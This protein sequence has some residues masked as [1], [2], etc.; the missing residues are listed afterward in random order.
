MILLFDTPGRHD[1]RDCL[2]DVM[3][4]HPAG[5]SLRARPGADVCADASTP[6]AAADPAWRQH[7]VWLRAAVRHRF[8]DQIADD[9]AQETYLRVVTR[10]SADAI[11]NPRGL[12]MAVA[13]NLARDVFRRERLRADYAARNARPPSDATQGL[14]TA[15]DDLA[16]RD[17]ILS[18]P[19]KLREVLLLSKIGGLTNRE[20]AQRCGLSVRAI[21][22]R[23]QKAIALFVVRLR[24]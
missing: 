4:R 9:L 19:P 2:G 12:L 18:L 3:S 20:I 10:A 11:E 23:L 24:D 21:D 1:A 13:S 17:A 22:K 15:E 5:A 16:V 6:S 8:G 14:H 7:L